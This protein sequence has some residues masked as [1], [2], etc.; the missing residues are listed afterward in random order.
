MENVMT[1]TKKCSVQQCIHKKKKKKEAF[2]KGKY[3]KLDL[4][5]LNIIIIK[6]KME[7]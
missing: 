4:G 1:T 3:L 5:S 2:L 7:K 6:K